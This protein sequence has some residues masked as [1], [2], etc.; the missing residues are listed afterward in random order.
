MEEQENLL[1]VQAGAIQEFNEEINMGRNCS[2]LLGAAADR[3]SLQE[4]AITLLQ[5]S[6]VTSR[7]I[8]ELSTSGLDQLDVAPFMLEMLESYNQLAEMIENMK[9]AMEKEGQVEAQTPELLVHMADLRSALESASINMDTLEQQA[10]MIEMQGRSIA[11]LTPLLR[12]SNS[13]DILWFENTSRSTGD[14]TDVSA[15]SCLPRSASTNHLQ[16]VRIDYQCQD[17]TNRSFQ[18]ACPGGVCSS[19]ELPSCTDSLE[20]EEEEVGFENCQELSFNGSSVLCGLNG[21]KETTKRLHIGGGIV[22]EVVTT[23]CND[24]GDLRAALEWTAWAPCTNETSDEWTSEETSDET[25]DDETSG[26]VI[27]GM[28][29]RRRG[30]PYIGYEEEDIIC[31][32]PWTQL[33]TGCYRFHESPMT[34]SE[35]KKFCEEEQEVPAR[36]VEIDS[37]EENRAIVAEMQRQ[38]SFSRKINFWLGI[39]DRHSEG[40]WVLEST[41]ESVVFTNWQSGEPN[42][43]G[44]PGSENCAYITMYN[45]WNDLDCNYPPGTWKR[46]AL[47]EK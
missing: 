39:N 47:C 34:Q 11:L 30:N 15:C 33:S 5:S 8:S 40:H 12:R 25:S 14:V 6:L 20:W 9:T 28:L 42:N 10:K 22:E 1:R 35:A 36:L 29:C 16:P 2:T 46:T 43:R 17:D 24:C 45:V 21:K 13:S 19:R 27:E 4:E 7:N 23:P 32:A 41:G 38:N 37:A 18:L 31:E 44:N 26:R 3:I